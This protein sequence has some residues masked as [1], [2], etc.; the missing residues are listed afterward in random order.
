MRRV[1]TAV[2]ALC[3]ALLP[4][5]RATGAQSLQASPPSTTAAGTPAQAPAA[6]PNQ[7][8]YPTVSLGVLSYLQYDAELKNRDDY[9]AF[10]VTRGYIN[11]VGDLAKNVRFR[12]T[13]D[14]RRVTDGSL[15]GS[16][17][18]R[19]KYGFAEFDNVLGDKSWVRFGLHQT[20]WLDFE[21]SINRYRVQGQMFAEREGIIPGSGDFGAGF[22]TPLPSGY[23]EIN[24][25]VYNG[26][27]FGSG[28]SNKYKSF[29][30]RATIR[31]LPNAPIAKGLRVSGFY[32]AGWY[33]A[34]H[35]RRH[36]I[37]MASFEHP[38]F[39]GT[40]QWLAGTERPVTRLVDAHPRGASLFA[41]VRQGLEG[42]AALARFETFDPDDATP[43]NSDRRVIAGA[44]YWLKWSRSR[45]GFVLDDEDV[46]Y[47]AGR[48]RPNEN[49]LLF[50]T[51][52]QF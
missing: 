52:I 32:D 8:T 4:S 48:N 23:G 16:L 38:H 17:A 37:V 22:L 41:E 20:P 36:G 45:I 18:L 10:D 2:A 19:L 44:A 9:N 39:V 15:S 40:A 11:I 50:Q 26:E 12:I 3:V 28:E 51:H 31:P 42:W 6:L 46:R 34:R 25:G 13:P 5:P 30:G 27:G 24:A 47:D 33:S 29:Q 7:P 43:N 35:P 49:R 14:V 21:E 1:R